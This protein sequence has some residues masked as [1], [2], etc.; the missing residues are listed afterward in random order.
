V[1]RELR[2]GDAAGAAALLHED[3]QPTP[4]TGPGILHWHDS[5]PERARVGSWVAVEGERVV[6]WARARLRWATS[7]EGVGEAWAFVSPSWR[8]RGLGAGLYER[9]AAHLD[10]VGAR[11]LESWSE[12]ADGGRFLEAR[13]FRPVRRLH[14]LRLDLPADVS[15]LEGLRAAREAEG[16][17]VV[18]LSA[19]LDRPRELHAVDAAATADVPMTYAED[20]FRYEDW[21]QE[22]LGHPQLSHE[23]SAVVLAAGTP[24]AYALLH[25]DPEARLA[26]NEMTGTRRDVRRRGLARLAKLVTIAWAQ[27]QGYEAIVTESD[28]ENVGMVALNESLG[29][30]A[31]ATETQ[32]LRDERARLS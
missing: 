7:A 26:A 10:R 2:P 16:F 32:Y 18:P 24:A 15:A 23:G 30:R 11:V 8:R 13:G 9:A 17:E 14:V 6:G 25:V 1:I 21:V 4:V 20:D 31:V 3:E 29:Y 27:E 28:S 19:V 5:Q 22:A 12:T